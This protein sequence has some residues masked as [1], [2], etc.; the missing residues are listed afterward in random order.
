MSLL[1]VFESLEQSGIGLLIRESLWLFPAIEAVH[2]LGLSVLGCSLLMV[3][4]RLFG[5]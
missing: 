4:L 5:V 2:L 3:D 1:D